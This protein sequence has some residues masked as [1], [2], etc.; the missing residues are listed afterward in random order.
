MSDWDGKLDDHTHKILINGGFRFDKKTKKYFWHHE[1]VWEK[2]KRIDKGK[3]QGAVP[4]ATLEEFLAG[5]ERLA[6]EILAKAKAKAAESG[7][8]KSKAEA[9]DEEEEPPKKKKKKAVEDEAEEEEEAPKKKKK[10]AKEEP[11]DDDE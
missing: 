4:A 10:K 8:S 9:E 1:A 11:E 7:A 5:E 2:Q 3:K 6:D